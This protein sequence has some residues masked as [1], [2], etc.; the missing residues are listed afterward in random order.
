[1]IR[2]ASCD[3]GTQNGF[4]NSV[5]FVCWISKCIKLTYVCLHGLIADDDF[6]V[7]SNSKWH[8]EKQLLSG[9][10]TQCDM[11]GWKCVCVHVGYK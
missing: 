2:G 10:S 8:S 1:M 11:P 3:S 7:Y 5:E 6:S 4:T 9:K